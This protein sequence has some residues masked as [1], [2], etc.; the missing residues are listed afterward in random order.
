VPDEEGA[1][2]GMDEEDEE[3]AGAGAPLLGAIISPQAV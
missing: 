1:G 2:A 3:L